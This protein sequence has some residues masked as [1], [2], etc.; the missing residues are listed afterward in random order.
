MGRTKPAAATNPI[1]GVLLGLLMAGSS[2]GIS[3]IDSDETPSSIETRLDKIAVE[4]ESA[5]STFERRFFRHWVDADADGCDTREEVLIAEALQEATTDPSDCSV[6]SGEWLSLYDGLTITDA[7]DLDID[8]VVALGEA[9]RSG[10]DAWDSERRR[11]YA[12]DRDESMA[13]IAVTAA[14][15]RSKGDK[16]PARWR[17]PDVTSWCA[18]ATMWI[19]VKVRW[20]LS[21]DPNEIEALQDMLDTC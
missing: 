5:A 6:E 7:S 11:A 14:T 2:A 12:N 1:I 15:N 18:Y 19:A 17:P 16:D 9:W 20:E 13:L 8:H 4:P 21:A 3:A 10:A